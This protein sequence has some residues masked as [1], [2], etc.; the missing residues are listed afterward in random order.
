VVVENEHSD[1]HLLSFSQ[2]MAKPN[3]MVEYLENKMN[4]KLV[5]VGHK[6]TTRR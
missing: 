2:A 4:L 1:Q 6:F 3:K 5:K